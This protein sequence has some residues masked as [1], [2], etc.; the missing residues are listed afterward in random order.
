M[1]LDVLGQYANDTLYFDDPEL[2]EWF[3]PV[4]WLDTVEEDSLV[5]ETGF[6]AHEYVV[7]QPRAARWQHTLDRLKQV[8]PNWT[9][10]P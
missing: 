2:A 9:D 1:L 3:L 5:W 4:R 6:F 8:F 10:C 7:L